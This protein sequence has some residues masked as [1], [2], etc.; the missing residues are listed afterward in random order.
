MQQHFNANNKM[1]LNKQFYPFFLK[2]I[3]F[4]N[5]LGEGLLKF[6]F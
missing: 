5:L 2:K 4:L 1:L 6:A 3:Y